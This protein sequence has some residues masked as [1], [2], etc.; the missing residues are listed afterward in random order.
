M[1]LPEVVGSVVG[2][3]LEFFVAECLSWVVLADPIPSVVVAGW[4]GSS[5][6]RTL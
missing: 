3:Q 1:G 5:G 2:L 4:R 6:V